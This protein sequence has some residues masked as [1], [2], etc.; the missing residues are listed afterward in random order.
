MSISTSPLARLEYYGLNADR[1]ALTP[2]F[3]LTR[4]YE[5]D[6]GRCYFWD[7]TAWVEFATAAGGAITGAGTPGRISQWATASSLTDSTL[8]KSGAGVLD[9]AAAGAY[10][11]TI[12]KTGT[13]VVGTGTATRIA[14]WVTDANTLQASTLIK[15]GAG[16]LTL[17]AGGAYTLTIPATGTAALGTGVA[18]QVAYWSGTNTVA[19]DAGMTYDAT[20]N[21]LLMTA[22]STTNPPLSIQGDT[23]TGTYSAGTG[24]LAWVA[25]G[26]VRW[27]MGQFGRFTLRTDQLNCNGAGAQALTINNNGN[28]LIGSSATFVTQFYGGGASGAPWMQVSSTAVRFADIA[29]SGA[30]DAFNITST[31]TTQRLMRWKNKASQTADALTYYDSDGTT[32]LTRIEADGEIDITTDSKYL[33]VGAGLDAGIAYDGTN[34]LINPKLVGTGYLS[35]LGD[36]SLVDEDIILGTTTG[37]KIGTATTQKLGFWNATP[38]VQPSGATQAAPAAYVTGGFGL[39]SDANMQALYD[40]VVAMRT[41]LVGAGIMKGS[42]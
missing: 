40:L 20:N 13:A 6:T 9:L 26:V 41:A 19:G 35:I 15:S 27:E 38:I 22:G 2:D 1:T 21:Q 42:A 39:D 25:A 3:T 7:G 8:T 11:F 31:T 12:P 4:F 28:L 37:T 36:I 29:D 32:I 17:D 24:R 33:R 10:T 5:T 34:M 16:V 23:N 18:N 30:N 14:E